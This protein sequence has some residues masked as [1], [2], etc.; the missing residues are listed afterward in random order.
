MVLSIQ[1]RH[2]VGSMHFQELATNSSEERKT[3]RPTTF[4]A[5]TGVTSKEREEAIVI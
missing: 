3:T 4:T 1:P 5:S 2:L